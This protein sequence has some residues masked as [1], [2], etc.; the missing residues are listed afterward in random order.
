LRLN[1]ASGLADMGTFFHRQGR[2]VAAR[3]CQGALVPSNL[4]RRT[5]R[6]ISMMLCIGP[7]FHGASASVNLRIPFCALGCFRFRC[8]GMRS[9]DK[10]LQ[11]VLRYTF[12]RHGPPDAA[13]GSAVVCLDPSA[14]SPQRWYHRS[15]LRF[16]VHQELVQ[17]VWIGR[18]VRQNFSFIWGVC[19]G[20]HQSLA[21]ACSSAARLLGS[22]AGA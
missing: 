2:L 19:R 1:V 16:R 13:V 21:C 20:V 14:S 6:K 4:E 22:A 18:S 11:H 17:D 7:R 5:K 3:T 9:F 8:P 12:S 10:M 15:C